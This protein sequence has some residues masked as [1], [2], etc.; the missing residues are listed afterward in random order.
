MITKRNLRLPLVSA[1][2]S[3]A[4][5]AVGQNSAVAVPPDVLVLMCDQLNAR[6][7]GCY[8]GPVPTPHIDRIAREGVLFRNASCPLPVCSPS[9]ATIV[10]G[11]YPHSHGITHNVMRRDYPMVPSPPTQEGIKVADVT[12]E[13][14][15]NKAGYATHFY[16]KW[17]LLDED[18]PYYTDMFTEHD[19]YAREMASDFEAVRKTDRE[20]WMDWYR[21]ALPVT[22]HERYRGAVAEAESVWPKKGDYLDFIRKIGRLEMPASKNFDVRVADRAVDRIR[23]MGDRPFMITCSFNAPHDPNVVPSP[24]YEMFDPGAIALP[25]NRGTREARQEKSWSR[26]MVAGFG[27]TG[28]RE[29][30]RV[31]YAMVK[32]IDDQVGRVLAALEEAGRIDNTVIVF[33][34]DHG[35]MAGGHG[36][37]WKSNGSFYDEIVLVPLLIRYPPR[38]RPQECE[39]E[40]GHVD[41]MPTLLGLA[42]QPC[43]KTAQGQSLVPFLTGAKAATEARPFAFCERVPPGPGDTRKRGA[44]AGASFMVRGQGWK[45]IRYSEGGEVL[46]DL[47]RDPGETVNRADDPACAERKRAM[48]DALADWQGRTG[49]RQ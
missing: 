29:F 46:Y 32:L 18:L 35:D 6:V 25:Q 47:K 12:T 45:Y 48:M 26:Q 20:S 9:R 17:H 31:Y 5:M 1:A 49:W 10:T 33:T 23:S 19:A 37:V 30:L 13:G 27:E 41:L 39:L 15:L 28:L 22:I 36:M 3:L 44:R 16:G 2:I 14:I 38:L 34:A 40:V 24:Y 8:G 43:T 7:L 11:L 4:L 42:G 21:W